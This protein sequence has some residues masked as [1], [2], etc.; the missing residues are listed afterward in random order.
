M[1]SETVD[2]ASEGSTSRM[3]GVPFEGDDVSSWQ[4]M[5]ITRML[6]GEG[7]AILS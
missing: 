3:V 1:W 5:H 4:V 6:L 2:G 7:L